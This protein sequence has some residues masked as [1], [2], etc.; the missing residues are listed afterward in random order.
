MTSIL[1]KHQTKTFG[2]KIYTEN[3]HKYSITAKVR[4]DDDCGNGHN[5]FAITGNIDEI[6]NGRTR[7]YSGGCIHEE[8]AKHFP[9]LK[10]FIKWHLTS[11]DGPMY[12]LDNTLYHASN[13]D[14]NGLLAGE[15]SK[16][17][18]HQEQHIKFNDVPVTYKLDKKFAEFLKSRIGTGEFKIMP[19]A[20]NENDTYDFKSKYTLI[21]YGEK[22]HDCPF[23]SELEAQKFADALNTC[24]VEFLTYPSLFGKGKERELDAA[25]NSAVW[26]EATDEQLTSDNLKELLIARLPALMSEFKKDVQSLG[27]I[28]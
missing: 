10:P 7:E 3:G 22:W 28:Y 26:P 5:S 11:S 13:R 25:R 4:Y 24:K 6:I 19:I 27:F 18:I 14:Y 9:E 17:P 2:P 16:N 8:I 1:T 15:T 23:N 20:Y 21:G 12:Y